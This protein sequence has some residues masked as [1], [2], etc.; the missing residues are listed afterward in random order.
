MARLSQWQ[1]ARA[2]L[3]G[4]GVTLPSPASVRSAH[5]SASPQWAHIGGGNLYRALHAQIAQD[6][7]D[8]GELAS[9]VTVLQ[10]HNPF[11]VEH[12]FKPYHGSTLQ[13][14][15]APDGAVRERVIDATAQALVA[16]P[17]HAEDWARAKEL[18]CEPSLQMVTVTITEKAYATRTADGA[19]SAAC[20]ADRAAGPGRP[21][22][23]MGIVA[24]LL[25]ERFM[26]GAAPVAMVSTD[27]FSHNGKVFR[28]A[29]LDIAEG[30]A[31]NGY[32]SQEFLGW[33]GNE[34]HVAFPWTMVDRIVPGPSLQTA[35]LLAGQGWDDLEIIDRPDA[36][37]VAGFVNCEEPW[38]LAVEDSFP[39]GRP[40]LEQAGVI[41]CSR[42]QAERAD[43]MKVCACLNPLHTAL[44][45]YGC[46]L[47]YDRIWKEMNDP[48]LVA[49][50]RRIGIMEGI[51]SCPNPE[52]L[53]PAAFLRELLEVRLPNR[54]LP[55]A[56]QRI[57]CD[58]SQKMP[59]RYGHTLGWHL[60]ESS[61]DT[62]VG[63]PLVFAGW[64]RYLMG[65]DDAGEPLALS[66]DPRLEEL[67]AHLAGLKLGEADPEV[68]HRAAAPILADAS[69]FGC[70]LYEAGIAQTVESLL[71]DELA[72]PGAVR[73]TLA[74]ELER[75]ESLS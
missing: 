4:R 51:P 5:S 3:E 44:A 22:T 12:V 72:G 39:N 62:L 49:L 10:V 24:A 15:L 58:T 46:L 20:H 38:Y 14:I 37:P 35:A 69:L 45:I 59:I 40:A 60:D 9:G 6:L 16:L 52:V 75:K 34:E 11:L 64:L 54:G 61:A 32:A 36:A 57:A 21:A 47:G 53:D 55:D 19:L 17:S 18:F 65:V 1:D 74:R 28:A 66:P 71:Q 67:R 73:A 63:L 7:L 42:E 56:P 30:W 31:E 13:A 29:V 25:L 2:T 48:E 70:D 41:M 23:S 33:L 68:I 8:T 27:N 26:S 50:V 43:T